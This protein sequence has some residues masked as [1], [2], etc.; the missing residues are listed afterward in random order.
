MFLYHQPFVRP[1]V[2]VAFV[3]Q[4]AFSRAM[5]IPRSISNPQPAGLPHGG[6]LTAPVHLGFVMG[7]LPRLESQPTST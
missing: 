7:L 5:L 4:V 1:Y 3:V 6:A 2:G